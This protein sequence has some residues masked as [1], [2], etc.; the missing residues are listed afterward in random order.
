[1][2]GDAI[3]QCATAQSYRRR[4]PEGV[5]PI[6]KYDLPRVF[7][8]CAYSALIGTPFTHYWFN[9]LDKVGCGSMQ[10]DKSTT[11]CLQAGAGALCF[12]CMHAGILSHAHWK[13]YLQRVALTIA[14]AR[15]GLHVRFTPCGW[16]AAVG[17]SDWYYCRLHD[18][19]ETY[20]IHWKT[21]CNTLEDVIGSYPSCC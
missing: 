12:G 7:R 8:L 2:I 10:H 13:I 5:V 9:F 3:A 11:S 14:M 20:C 1:M 6:F 21:Y 19:R 16:A 17:S 15:G 18:S 4:A